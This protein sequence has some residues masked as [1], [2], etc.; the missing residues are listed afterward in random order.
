MSRSHRTVAQCTLK[1]VFVLHLA[2]SALS[3]LLILL[4]TAWGSLALGYQVKSR[5][6]KVFALIFWIGAAATAIGFCWAGRLGAALGIFLLVFGVLLIWWRQI[7]PSN[8]RVWAEDVSKISHADIDGDSVVIHNVR[9]FAWQTKTKFTARWESR[10]YD[11]TQLDSADM[12]LSH[13]SGPAI[14]HM[15]I[16]FGFEDGQYLAFSVE[17]RRELNESFSELGGFFKQFELSIIACEERDVVRVRTNVRREDAFLYRLNMPRSA[18]RSL[19]LGYLAQANDL[20]ETPRFY[21]T[22]TT[23]CTTL[24]YEMLKR[25][26][27]R[28]PLDWRVLITGYLPAY[29]HR[30]GGLDSRYS[31]AEL[32]ELGHI[33][34]RARLADQSSTFSADIRRGIPRIVAPS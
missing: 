8:D 23:N 24:V 5:S 7:P 19:F 13:W 30:V 4:V 32:T 6:W 26:V 15:L 9:N 34:E 28:L 29:V 16:S 3:T 25:I 11:L 33:T 12:I 14:A 1:G 27:G 10:R 2:F 22:I 20:V 21:N 17:I 31:L 18:M